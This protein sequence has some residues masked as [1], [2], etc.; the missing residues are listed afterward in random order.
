METK[1]REFCRK[2]ADVVA[3]TIEFHVGDREIRTLKDIVFDNTGRSHLSTWEQGGQDYSMSDIILQRSFPS[4]QVNIGSYQYSSLVYP[5]N[6]EQSAETW[7]R[8]LNLDDGNRYDIQIGSFGL[9]IVRGFA[10][11]SLDEIK[12]IKLA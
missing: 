3:Q 12:D 9:R 7:R 4:A 5:D 6:E 1:K 2:L 11:D 8:L 10:I